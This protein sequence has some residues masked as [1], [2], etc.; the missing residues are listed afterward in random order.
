MHLEKKLNKKDRLS[1]EASLL[2]KHHMYNLADGVDKNEK[3]LQKQ[4]KLREKT[5]ELTRHVSQLRL[6]TKVA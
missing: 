3:V 5:D 4:D 2:D 6:P 1:E